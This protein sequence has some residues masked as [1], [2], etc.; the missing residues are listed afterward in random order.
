M[1]AAIKEISIAFYTC[2]QYKHPTVSYSVKMLLFSW[3]II[4]SIFTSRIQFSISKILKE[5]IV[6]A[7]PVEAWYIWLAYIYFYW[8]I[9]IQRIVI[10][11]FRDLLAAT[12][13][14][15]LYICK[16]RKTAALA[17]KLSKPSLSWQSH[18]VVANRK[19]ISNWKETI[20]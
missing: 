5:T 17:R 16:R 6:K 10:E 13:T 1:L 19:Q 2:I 18:L 20:L 4:A 8:I 3:R 9:F 15:Y 12:R 7:L 11:H 14:S